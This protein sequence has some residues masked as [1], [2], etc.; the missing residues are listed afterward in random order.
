MADKMRRWTMDAVGRAQLKLAETAIPRPGN[1]EILVKVSAVALNYRDKLVIETGFG[2]ELPFPFTPASDLA[3]IVEAVGPQVSRFRK[4]DRVISTFV[5]GWIDGKTSGTARHPAHVTL[6]GLLQGVL[7]EYVVL[8]QDWAVVAPTTLNDA[9]AS[10]LPVAGLTAWS[11]LVEEGKLAAGQTVVVLGTG[12][13]SLF[14]LQIAAAHG[15]QVIVTSGEEE[16]LAR[17]KSLGAAH[18][19]NRKATDW[20]KAV[21]DI[22]DGRG[23]DHILEIAGGA[24]LGRSLEACAVGGRISVIGVIEGFEI[25]GG[26]LPLMLK[27]VTVRGIIVG[28]RRALEDLTRAV[29]RTGIKPVIDAEYDLAALPAALDH[30]E[31]GPF[32]KVVVRMR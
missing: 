18:G 19:I 22:T 28:H 9:E 16:K 21:L 2:A 3:G 4:G 13:V 31:R 20:A 25:S 10:T 12:G 24:N 5:P 15:A 7:A 14:G 6:G 30:L 32:G 1:G 17:A 8:S 27:Q 26:V 23:A 11:A 29:D